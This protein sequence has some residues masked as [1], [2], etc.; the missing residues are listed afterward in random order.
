MFGLK[1]SDLSLI[2]SVLRKH[3][4]VEEAIIFGSR[5]MGNY[6]PGSDVDIAL[7]GKLHPETLIRIAIELNQNLPLPYKFDLIDYGDLSPGP[8]IEHIE[9]HGRILYTKTVGKS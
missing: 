4:D 5:A 2:L 6:K 1:D 3:P 7:K 8:F 9:K